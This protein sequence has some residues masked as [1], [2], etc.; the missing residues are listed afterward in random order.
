MIGQTISHYRIVEKLGGGG[1]GVVYKAKDIKLHR[2]VALKF[3]PDEVA[4]DDQALARF[5]RE[6]QAASALNHPNICTIYE[7]DDQHGEAFIAMEFLDGLTLKHRIGGKPMESEEVLSLG[8]EIADALDAAHSAGIVHRDIKPANIF[9]TKR[10]HAKILD[11]GLAKVTPVPSELGE[12]EATAASTVALEEHLTSPGQ[13]VGTI[14]Y[15]SPEQVR[16][17]E[18]DART[19]LFSFGAVLYEMATGALPFRGESSGV[20]FKT[21]LDGTPTPA[22]R[23]N[24]DLPPKLEDIINKCLEKDRNLRYQ[25]AADIRTDLQRLKRDAESARVPLPQPAT[26]SK[27]WSRLL[28]VASGIAVVAILLVIG[29]RWK[30]SSPA[31]HTTLSQVTFTEG[32]EEYPAWSPDGK[33]LLYTG[34]VGKIRKIFRKDLA[35]GQDSQLTRGDSD[36]LQPAWSPD[37]K[38]VAFVRAH[39]PDVKLQPG[40]VFGMFQEGD[41]WVLDLA[42]G[43][44]TKLVE[45]AF[46][47]AYSPDGQHLAVDASWAAARRIW[48]LDRQGHNP[49]QVTTDTS[50]EVAHVAP[51]WSPDGR[52]IVFQNL[53]RTKFDIRT[54]NL[55]S[56]Q[57]NWITNDS[58]TNIRPSWSPSGRFI[59]FS[60][61]RS[62]GINIW[63]APVRGDGTVSGSLQQVTTGAG[64]DVEVAVSPDS[65]RLAYATL[66]QNADI[67]RLPVSPQTGLSTRTPEAVIST[68]R[69]DSRGAWSPDAK[70][71]A[72]N[73]D[74][75]G[76][77]NIWLYTL[78]DSTTRQLTTGHG[79]DFQPNWSPDENKFAFFSSRSGSPNI[80]EVEIASGTLR[81]LT[82]NSGVNVNPFYSPD[83][84]FIAYQ[85]DQSGRLEVWV[86]NG[87]GS[88]PRRLTNVGV[89]GHFMRW[90]ADGLGIVFRCTYNGKP[91]TM[92]VS[93]SGGEPQPFAE[94][95]MGGSH[96]SFSPDRTRI[97]DVVGHKVLWVSPV[98]G[99]KPE[100]VYEFPDP[101]VRIDYPVWSPDGRWV[102]FDRFRPQG[103]DIWAM[104]GVE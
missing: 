104:S 12:A 10:G 103:G 32:V 91:A 85:S 80:W 54:V 66:R 46:N 65:K 55:D 81:R 16:A 51:A 21:I 89:M 25:H 92:K 44:E 23:L 74:R 48:V 99:G 27:K 20:I 19:D 17:K 6:A 49:Q 69:E 90:A 98:N 76:D 78:A 56:K 60:S 29:A 14:A 42:S 28:A 67:W 75:S 96:M 88:N 59:Y 7:I 33:A 73:S 68:T 15:M 87:D 40:D 94:T 62:G 35:S 37:G 36:E 63:R 93:L 34:E 57:M 5:Q 70:M 43:E 45:N 31:L 95:M 3:L 97:M 18:L 47:P 4:K 24:P 84:T 71:V 82:S 61:Y 50:E 53:V 86:M 2:F 41:V 39:Q 83:G 64:Q 102:M 8:I 100:K 101:D 11:F 13:A 52:K 30:G 77:M 58:L 38:Q 72:F 26:P 22:V 9:V 1:M 79:S